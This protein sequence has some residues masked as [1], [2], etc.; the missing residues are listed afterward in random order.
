M[1]SYTATDGG[2]L[3]AWAAPTGE[4]R[5]VSI[6]ARDP[7][8]KRNLVAVWRPEGPELQGEPKNVHATAG[9][10]FDVAPGT[11]F[12]TDPADARLRVWRI[13]SMDLLYDSAS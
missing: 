12:S 2:N 4:P 9:D 7:R 6:V 10:L 8:G 1:A 5:A 13:P 11:V 3:Y